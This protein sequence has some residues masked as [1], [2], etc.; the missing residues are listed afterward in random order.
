[1]TM[2]TMPSFSEVQK[3]M[4]AFATA[5]NR[6]IVSFDEAIDQWDKFADA[7]KQ[8]RGKGQPINWIP[9]DDDGR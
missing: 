7:L 2:M 4:E 6:G 9:A 8:A 5:A 3:A 1:M